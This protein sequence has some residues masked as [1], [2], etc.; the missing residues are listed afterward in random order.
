MAPEQARSEKVDHHCDLF[1]L[2]VVLYRMCT[3]RLPFTGSSTMAVLTSLAMDTPKFVGDLNPTMPPELS[4]L[5]MQ[6]LSKDPAMR[7]ASAKDVAKRFA[8]L[9]A[10]MTARARAEPVPRA[11]PVQPA[12]PDNPWMDMDLTVPQSAARLGS[13][14]GEAESP[15]GGTPRPSKTPGVPPRRNRVLVAA[16]AAAIL[17]AGIVTIRVATDKGELVIKADEAVEVTIKR[18]GKP[19]EDLELKRGDNVTSI[20]SGDIE[21]VL[22][23]AD[24]DEFV[25]KNNRITLKRGDK[26]VVEIERKP[27]RAAPAGATVIA[28]D[29][30]VAVFAPGLE[31]KGIEALKRTLSPDDEPASIVFAKTLAEAGKIDAGVLLI[32][33]DGKAFEN[34]GEYSVQDLKK[35]KVIGVGYGAAKLFGELELAIN[36]GACAHGVPGVPRIQVQPNPLIDA[37]AFGSPFNVF[38]PPII[39]PKPNGAHN[40]FIFGVYVGEKKPEIRKLIDIIAIQTAMKDYAPVARQ[41]NYVLICVDAPP[42]KWS[43]PFERLVRNIASQLRPS[44]SGIADVDRKAAEWVLSV[45]GTLRV[46]ANDKPIGKAADLPKDSFRIKSVTLGAKPRVQDADLEQL[47]GLVELEELQMG[48]NPQ[49]G[50]ASL[51][52]L[53]GLTSLQVLNLSGN[54]QLTDVGLQHLQGLKKLQGIALDWAKITDAGLEHL[55]GHSELRWLSLF[56]TQITDAGLAHLQGLTELEHIRLGGSPQLTGTGFKHLKALPKLHVLGICW[57]VQPSIWRHIGQLDRIE[58]LGLND[59]TVDDAALVQLRGMTKL[60]HLELHRTPITDAGLMHLKELPNLTSLVINIKETRIVT[61]EGLDALRKAMPNCAINGKKWEGDADRRAAEWVLSIGGA[62]GVRMNNQ[63]HDVKRL[64]DLPKERF[65]LTHVN[66]LL[67]DELVQAH[68]ERNP[69]VTDS[70]L[71]NLKG[72]SNLTELWLAG[73]TRVGDAGMEHLKDLTKLTRLNLK[74][75]QVSNAGLVHLKGLSN[76]TGLG[77][78][79]TRVGDAGL[80]HLKALTILKELDLTGTDVT[81]EGVAAL[82]KALPKCKIAWDGSAKK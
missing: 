30:R 12:A 10:S 44:G 74:Y 8:D 52:P 35:R 19:V 36:S 40:D 49:L 58:S 39:D 55:K 72:L 31:S 38:D 34:V 41:G 60:K 2:G 16:F 61:P 28:S 3:G 67:G 54:E 50:D 53:R 20:Y 75:T 29:R 65:L 79:H 15:V 17:L 4:N 13:A 81:A 57:K 64:A 1:S 11:L 62:V 25:I 77:L 33:M 71:E 63:P 69:K 7:P 46:T 68:A 47:S 76:L 5:V 26:P 18:N 37:S 23:D 21:V 42:D 45:G 27:K 73:S 78:G 80:E 22:K 66:V 24:P 59:S 70:G 48:H 9:E 14:K 82:Q 6:L 56:G 51:K 43:A 32:I